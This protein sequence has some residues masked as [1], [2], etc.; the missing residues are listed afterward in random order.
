MHGSKA[1][2]SCSLLLVALRKMFKILGFRELFRT[3]LDLTRPRSEL[4]RPDPKVRTEVRSGNNKKPY[5]KFVVCCV[6]SD[7]PLKVWHFPCGKSKHPNRHEPNRD[8]LAQL[9]LLSSLSGVQAELSHQDFPT[10]DTD[11]YQARV[12]ASHTRYHLFWLNSRTYE[13]PNRRRQRKQGELRA[14]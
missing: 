4:C 6:K 14:Q 7:S 13:Q 3:R 12:R 11:H 10:E 5:E 9:A 8:K 2:E 1:T